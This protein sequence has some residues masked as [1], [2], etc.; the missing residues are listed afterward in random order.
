MKIKKFSFEHF[1][2]IN[3]AEL[4]LS[5]S[6]NANVFTLVGPNECGKTTVLEAIHSLKFDTENQAVLEGIG[7]SDTS[8]DFVRIGDKGSFNGEIKLSALTSIEDWEKDYIIDQ[9]NKKFGH[10]LIKENINNELTFFKIHKF[11]NGD[12]VENESNEY[13]DIGSFKIREKIEQSSED[14]DIEVSSDNEEEQAEDPVE[15]E[16]LYK[17]RYI[18]DDEWEFL[19]SFISVLLPKILYFPNLLS[20]FPDKIYLDN[21][22]VIDPSQK[23]INSFYLTILQDVLVASKGSTDNHLNIKDHILDRLKSGTDD[24]KQKVQNLLSSMGTRIT[25]DIQKDWN[26]IFSKNEE[27]S[28]QKIVLQSGTEKKKIGEQS[29]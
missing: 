6:A 18:T 25:K 3:K 10:F 26:E 23:E 7:I 9:Y 5:K 15:T 17:E 11:N 4:N 13:W 2:G 29:V 1:K 21:E 19:D 22:H 27:V 20:R 16:T 28:D 8:D 14:T 24:N 12:Y